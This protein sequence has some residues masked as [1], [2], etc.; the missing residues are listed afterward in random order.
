M[1]W[2]VKTSPTQR[3]LALLRKD[4][5]TAA[6]VEKWNPHAFIRQDLYGFI[7]IVAIRESGGILGI[8]ACAGAS[9]A[10]RRTKILAEP[11]AKLWLQAGG[12]IDICS[13]SKKGAR[14]KRKLWDARVEHLTL[15]DFA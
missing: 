6:I 1:G 14:G 11:R 15:A 3:T 8:Q 12:L 5:W 4:G 10:T 13:W 9:H 7:D 2:P